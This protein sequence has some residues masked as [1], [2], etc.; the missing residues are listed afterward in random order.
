MLPPTEQAG[1]SPPFDGAECAVGSRMT[2]R[3]G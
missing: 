1:V 3:P 2:D